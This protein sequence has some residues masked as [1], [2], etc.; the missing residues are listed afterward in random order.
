MLDVGVCFSLDLVNMQ[1][2]SFA[3]GFLI[4]GSHMTADALQ[5]SFNNVGASVL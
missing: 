2:L 3:G 4:C 5:D 1:F